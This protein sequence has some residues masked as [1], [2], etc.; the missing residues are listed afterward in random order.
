MRMPL[1]V[2]VSVGVAP[3][4]ADVLDLDALLLRTVEA[5]YAAKRAG[6]TRV[7][8]WSWDAYQDSVHLS[9]WILENPPYGG[10]LNLN[11]C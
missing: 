11:E 8:I 5:L 2:T 1:Q 6:R 7:H 3:L 4:T 9:I 10:F